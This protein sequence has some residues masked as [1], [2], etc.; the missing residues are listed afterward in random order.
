MHDCVMVNHVGLITL[1]NSKILFIFIYFQIYEA[2]L[3]NTNLLITKQKTVGSNLI[4][5]KHNLVLE[6]YLL[7]II[8]FVIQ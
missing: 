2:P 3:S 8:N 4:R 6:E 5:T 7:Q 1:I